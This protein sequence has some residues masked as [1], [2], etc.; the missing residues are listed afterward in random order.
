MIIGMPTLIELDDLLAN[1]ELCKKLGLGLIEINLNLPHYQIDRLSI[2]ELRRIKKKYQLD[3]TFHLPED[4]ELA[5]FNTHLRKAYWDIVWQVIEVMMAIDSK[6]VTMHM[7]EG[8]YFSLPDKKVYLYEKYKDEYMER[9]S[10]FTTILDSKLENRAIHFGIENT[11]IYNRD[12]IVKGVKELLKCPQVS[13]TWDIGHD[14]SSGWKDRGFILTNIQ[15]LSHLHLHNAIG[16][17]NHLPLDNG[18]LDIKYW[19]K[20]ISDKKLTA[21][22]ETKTVKALTQSVRWL[23]KQVI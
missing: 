10:S 22:I 21:V 5:H 12:F 7:S 15:R 4:L 1:A 16:S 20:L 17:K 19:L 8:I 14:A 6:Q 3:F 2:N 9:I 11:G 13:L 23:E 18:D